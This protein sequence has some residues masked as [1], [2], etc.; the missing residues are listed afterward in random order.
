MSKAIPVLLKPRVLIATWF[1][2]YLIFFFTIPV[3]GWGRARFTEAELFRVAATE[4][5]V[6]EFIF[7]ENRPMIMKMYYEARSKD[8]TTGVRIFFALYTCPTLFIV[9]AL[10]LVSFQYDQHISKDLCRLGIIIIALSL[11]TFVISY[12]RWS[13]EGGGGLTAY[14]ILGHYF[15]LFWDLVLTGLGIYLLFSNMYWRKT[16][17]D[18]DSNVSFQKWDITNNK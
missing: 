9:V 6:G 17:F 18:A 7:L 5:H 8:N 1:L 13:Y 14:P 2:F 12:F 3:V 11:V 4:E 15:L 16:G 10:L